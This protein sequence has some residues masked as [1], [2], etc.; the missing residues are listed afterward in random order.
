MICS[1]D[2]TQRP[3]AATDVGSFRYMEG[4]FEICLVRLTQLPYA[5]QLALPGSLAGPEETLDDSARRCFRE[6]TGEEPAHLEQVH[7][8]SDPTRDPAQRCVS[9][10]YLVFPRDVTRPCHPCSK[11]SEAVWHEARSLPALAYDHDLI[12]GKCLERI[13]GKLQYTTLGLRLLPPDFTL[14]ELQS[15]YETV[16]EHPLDKRNF[17]KKV[18]SLD[19]LVETGK[20]RRGRRARPAG[21]FRAT[22]SEVHEIPLFA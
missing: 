12:L 8:F 22:N 9:T 14:S 6:A 5:Q 7:T 18:L 13:R 3:F 17:R 11:Y 1:P 10:A 16:L 15:L 2:S 20:L 19:I 4:R 21:L